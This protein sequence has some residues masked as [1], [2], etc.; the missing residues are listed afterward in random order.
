L[1]RGGVGGGAK[2]AAGLRDRQVLPGYKK[3][4]PARGAIPILKP[5]ILELKEQVTIRV[6]LTG[7]L[8]DT[9]EAVGA[10]ID[11]ILKP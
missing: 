7:K 5:S 8:K 1:W 6:V 10:Y 9:N 11:L 2:H 3:P 4:T